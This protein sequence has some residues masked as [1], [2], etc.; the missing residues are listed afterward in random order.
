MTARVRH[1]PFHPAC[2]LTGVVLTRP[3]EPQIGRRDSSSSQ[4]ATA[5]TAY[6]WIAK[7]TNKK[8]QLTALL[9]WNCVQNEAKVT[10]VTI[11]FLFLFLLPLFSEA[12]RQPAAVRAGKQN[13]EPGK[14]TWAALNRG[15]KYVL[16]DTGVKIY[17]AESP[18]NAGMKGTRG[19]T[20]HWGKISCLSAPQQKCKLS[21]S[22]Y[23]QNFLCAAQSYLCGEGQA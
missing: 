3:L 20:I 17:P 6:I 11:M 23:L 1:T 19:D 8:R 15:N 21:R 16:D 4:H 5:P 22:L 9:L 10:A 7:K 2:F 18:G 13:K 12:L 14:P